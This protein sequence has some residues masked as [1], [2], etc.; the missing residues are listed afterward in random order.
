MK[1]GS[2]TVSRQAQQALKTKY[3]DAQNIEWTLRGNYAVADF[4]LSA[5]KA[6]SSVRALSVRVNTGV[7]PLVRR[8]VWGAGAPRKTL[9]AVGYQ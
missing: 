3:P 7:A 5:K 6:S 1:S 9:K 2:G 4:S 8:S